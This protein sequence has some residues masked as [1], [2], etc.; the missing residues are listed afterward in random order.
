MFSEL[1]NIADNQPSLCIP[2]VFN[3]IGENT[4]RKVFDE[5]NLGQIQRVDVLERKNEKGEKFKRVYIHF[6]KWYWNSDAQA[7][8]SKLISGREI[9]IVYDNPWFWKVSANKWENR[10]SKKPHIVVDNEMDAITSSLSAVSIA[11]ALSVAPALTPALPVAS[12]LPVVNTLPVAPALTPALQVASA[13][14][15]ASALPVAPALKINEIGR[16]L[17]LKKKDVG[18]PS[19]DVRNEGK[20][21]EGKRDDRKR[22]DRK[23]DDRNLQKKSE[24]PKL[25]IT[26]PVASRSPPNSPPSHL[27]GTANIQEKLD[28]VEQEYTRATYPRDEDKEPDIEYGVSSIPPKKRIAWKKEEKVAELNVDD[29]LYSD[30]L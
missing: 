13:L 10:E 18:R 28:E 26:I 12:A 8:R 24:E 20:R 2:R 9:K 29:I 19:D 23:R 4:V 11:P 25:K 6:E 15:V 21:N 22:D 1:K 7:T 30:I 5:L 3:N 17:V 27:R 14:S 16:N